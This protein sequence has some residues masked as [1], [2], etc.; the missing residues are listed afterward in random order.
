VGEFSGQ[1]EHG[2]GLANP[3]FLVRTHDDWRVGSGRVLGG[4][5]ARIVAGGGYGGVLV[6]LRRL[7]FTWNS[8][9]S[10]GW[11]AVARTGVS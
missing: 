6:G 3:A 11:C 7:C 10:A 1:I 8:R 9:G 2:G 5:H 4:I